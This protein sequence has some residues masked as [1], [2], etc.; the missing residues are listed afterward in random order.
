LRFFGEQGT[1]FSVAIFDLTGKLLT[2]H[3][4]R[5]ES[6]GMHYLDLF[7][8]EGKYPTGMYLVKVTTRGMSRSIKVTR[9]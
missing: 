8:E 6:T 4:G 1:S 5:L 3:Q 9:Y 7:T 2:S